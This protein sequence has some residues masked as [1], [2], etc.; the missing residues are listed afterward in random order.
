MEHKSMM[1]YNVVCGLLSRV[2]LEMTTEST[3]ATTLPKVISYA[4]EAIKGHSLMSVKA[5][6]EGFN[7]LNNTEWIWGV[8][9][10][11]DQCNA[12]LTLYDLITDNIPELSYS[13]QKKWFTL[14][15][16]VYDKIP[17]ND[18]RREMWVDDAKVY[19]M[20]NKQV[21]FQQKPDHES[22]HPFMRVAEMVLVQA[23]AQYK[24]GNEVEA[25]TLL[26]SLRDSRNLNGKAADISTKGDA[27][28]AE[29]LM[30]RR[31]EL[32][33]EGFRFFDMKR[34]DESMDRPIND[35]NSLWYNAQLPD[36]QMLY[37]SK[38]D[39]LLNM[40]I[41][42]REFESNKALDEVKDQNPEPRF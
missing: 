16:R 10:Q 24:L 14:D 20:G 3:K 1:S 37:L 35:P 36:A 28:L 27:L 40:Q 42:Y 18:V 6:R 4:K 9:V 26:Q 22:A 39:N 19:R 29:I 7:N 5:Y 15:N 32:W 23:E 2:Y 21:K 25:K 33:G 30:E 13:N 8:N 12:F 38:G 41:P 34:N 17:A 11:K 31:Y